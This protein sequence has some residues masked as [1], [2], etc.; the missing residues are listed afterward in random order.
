[1]KPDLIKR[2]AFTMLEL[3]V[4]IAMIG[5]LIA[6]LLPGVHSAREAARRM[7]CAHHLAQIGLAVKQFENAQGV[8]PSGT[9]NETGPIRNVPIGD[10]LGWIPR[11]LPY[12]E[13]MP[14]YDKIDFTKGAYD[15]ENHVAWLSNSPSTLSCPSDGLAWGIQSSYMACNGSEEAPIDTTNNGVFFL[16]SKL[17]SRDIPDGAANT[18][19][20]GESLVDPTYR[21]RQDSRSRSGHIK[22]LLP[23]E[24]GDGFTP[25]HQTQYVYGGLGWISGTPGTI[26][27]T[28]NPINTLVGPFSDW[29]MPF[30]S[31]SWG[32]SGT[33]N[34]QTFPWLVALKETAVDGWGGRTISV[35]PLAEG[36]ADGEKPDP[37]ETWKEEKPG[38]FLVGGYSSYHTGGANFLFGDG[39][40]RLLSKNIDLQLYHNLGNRAD[41]NVVAVP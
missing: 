5:I 21:L 22:C 11:I 36:M 16:N 17:R 39:N 12:M 14:L 13:Q 24:D 27:N 20:I 3:L 23:E 29:P 32:V 40:V 4:V 31:G 10:H 41:G 35:E 26:R 9:V 28:A 37:A 8:L 1:M 15:P 18:I 7:Q 30:E 19:W 33:P 2:R 38:Q 6:L 34:H 25:P